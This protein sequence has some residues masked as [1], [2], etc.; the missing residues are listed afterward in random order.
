MEDDEG[1]DVVIIFWLGLMVL[2]FYV[3]QH[4]RDGDENVATFR[5]LSPLGAIVARAIL[6]GSEPAAAVAIAAVVASF[7]KDRPNLWKKKAALMLSGVALLALSAVSQLKVKRVHSAYILV[8]A[9]TVAVFALAVRGDVAPPCQRLATGAILA[10]L[11]NA[12][13]LSAF[14]RDVISC[15][16]LLFTSLE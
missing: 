7:D 1:I 9:C 3:D 11:S 15:A 13:K 5:V 4:K 2:Q 16:S 10:G 6:P 8:A 14:S 12:R